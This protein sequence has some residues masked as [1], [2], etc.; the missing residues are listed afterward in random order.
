MNILAI[1]NWLNL[2]AGVGL[3]A[4]VEKGDEVLH[5]APDDKRDEVL[6]QAPDD[7]RVHVPKR[8]SEDENNERSRLASMRIHSEKRS[9]ATEQNLVNVRRKVTTEWKTTRTKIRTAEL[10][11]FCPVLP[12]YEREPAE[13]Q[14]MNELMHSRI[15]AILASQA[16]LPFRSG[17]EQEILEEA[18]R[19][20]SADQSQKMVDVVEGEH[21]LNAPW[22]HNATWLPPQE[23]QPV[24]HSSWAS[25]AIEP[26]NGSF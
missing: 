20:W 11:W 7:K 18:D 8:D 15:M 17:T 5:Q 10:H 14:Q 16:N 2:R 4:Q 26:G 23:A 22:E 21:W 3:S 13:Y 25:P 12:A 24:M 9:S 6:H 19:T 1:F